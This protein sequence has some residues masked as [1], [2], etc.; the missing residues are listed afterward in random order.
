MNTILKLLSGAALLS[1]MACGSGETASKIKNDDGPTHGECAISVDATFAPL[2]DSQ[3]QVFH[4]IYKKTKI[5]SFTTSETEAI[6][7]LLKDSV[8]LAVVSRELTPAELD[9]IKKQGFRPPKVLHVA[10][11]AVA[12]ITH[13]TN[14][15]KGISYEKLQEITQGKIKNWSGVSGAKGGNIQIVFDNANSSTMRLVTDSLNAGAELP[16]NV[17]ATNNTQEVI[18][19]VAK[20]PGAIGFI[21]SNYICDEED[22]SHMK[23]LS[24]IN[25]VGVNAKLGQK[26]CGESWL[27]FQAHIALKM[28]PLRRKIYTICREP[29]NGL[30][31]GFNAFIASER[32]QR[33]V[34]KAA[35]VPATMPLRIV[36]IKH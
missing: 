33:I 21:G 36:Q 27:P 29:R 28:Y 8:R 15:L 12:V 3:L 7:L 23:F 31:T 9:I 14:Q 26:G 10:S 4:A 19:Y 22:P 24:Q 16:S 17:F 18:D 2:I 13:P 25:V 11:D 5:T 1:L 34:E 32:G 35:L 6:G 20:T 30:G